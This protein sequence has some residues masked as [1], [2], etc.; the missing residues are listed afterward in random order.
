MNVQDRIKKA[1]IAIMQHKVFCVYSGILACG[2]VKVNDDVPTAAT[3]GWDVVYNPAF[4]EE[5][6]KT[7]PELR[8]L[9]LHEAQ[10][11]AY[12]HLQVWSALHD[13]DAQLANIAADHFVNLSLV[14]TDAGEGFI[15]M[16]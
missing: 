4:I 15:K 11:K 6:M 9:V 7:D 2:K 1:H 13:E 12:R 5:H 16:P 10:H 8:F 14:D 3:N